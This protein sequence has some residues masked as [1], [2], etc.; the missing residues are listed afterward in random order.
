MAE[1]MNSSRLFPFMYRGECYDG[2]DAILNGF[3]DVASSSVRPNTP[4]AY[5]LLIVVYQRYPVQ[6]FISH[7]G[8][9]FI[10]ANSNNTWTD[11]VEK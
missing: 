7:L 10:R 9:L 4:A 3:Y 11:W 2:N 5:G 8:K 1:L 6:V